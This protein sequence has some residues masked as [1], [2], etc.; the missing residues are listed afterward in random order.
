MHGP[1][2]LLFL[3][4]VLLQLL[5]CTSGS[6]GCLMALRTS[7]LLSWLRNRY[8]GGIAIAMVT[9]LGV[10][11]LIRKHC[12]HF[13]PSV[14]KGPRNRWVKALPPGKKYAVCNPAGSASGIW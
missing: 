12:S 8:A 10:W 1:Y 13:V 7:R 14:K 5:S 11:L 9:E 3:L 2:A 4:L 6:F